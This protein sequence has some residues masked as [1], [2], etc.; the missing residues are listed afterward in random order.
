M[1]KSLLSLGA[2]AAFAGAASAQSTVTLYGLLDLNVQHLRSGDASP[3]AGGN[4]TR[5][6]DGGTYGPGS[7]WGLRLS[8]D[9]GSGLKANVVLESGFN[10]DTGTSSQGGRLFG[11]QAF[12]SLASAAAGE[13]RLGRQYTLHD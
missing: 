9:L 8:E 2:L 4:L 10:G 12:V 7:R 11:R 13:I 3:L 6:A 5:L 1:K